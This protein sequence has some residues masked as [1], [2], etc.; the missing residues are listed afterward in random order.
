MKVQKEKKRIGRP[1]N[2]SGIYKKVCSFTLTQDKWETYKKL[3]DKLAVNRSA[4][5][6][7]CVDKFIEDNKNLL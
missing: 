1:L 6:E 5:V 4:W 2:A 7:L 3:C